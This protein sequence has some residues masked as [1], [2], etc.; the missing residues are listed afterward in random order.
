M[1]KI[2]TFFLALVILS[3]YLTN[4]LLFFPLDL[5]KN[6]NSLLGYVAAAIGIAITVWLMGD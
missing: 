2:L 4:V 6:L 1:T 5:L 3:Y